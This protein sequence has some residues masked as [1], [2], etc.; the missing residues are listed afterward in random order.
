MI[1]KMVNG[2]N[3]ELRV[4]TDALLNRLLADK[5]PVLVLSAGVGDLVVQGGRDLPVL[6]PKFKSFFGHPKFSFHFV[7]FN[8]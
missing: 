4:G 2:S 7:I 5:V 3:V 1:P 6:F 8:F